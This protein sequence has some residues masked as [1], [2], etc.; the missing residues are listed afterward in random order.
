MASTATSPFSLMLTYAASSPLPT[1]DFIAPS[2]SF[3]TKPLFRAFSLYPLAL[4]ARERRPSGNGPYDVVVAALAAEAEV[5]EAVEEVE[6][7]EGDAVSTA[8]PPKPK[9]GKAALLLKRD[10]TRSKRF[11]EIQKLRENK[12][13]YDLQTAISLLKQMAS[14]RFVETAEAHFRLNIDPKY[15]DQQLRATVNLPKGTGQTVKVAVLTQGMGL[16]VYNIPFLGCQGTI[17]RLKL[18]VR[19][20]SQWRW[21]EIALRGPPYDGSSEH[22]HF[23]KASSITWTA[24]KHPLGEKFDEAKNAGAD[25]VGG[26]D[27]IEQIKGGFMDFDKLIA[28]PDMMPKVASLGKLLGPRGL[29][30]NPKA[31]TVTT[32]IPQAIAEFKKGKVEY[33]ADKTGIVHLPFGKADFSEEDLLANLIAAVKSVETNKPSGAKGVYWRSAPHM[34]FHGAFYSIK[35]K[36][37]A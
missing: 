16:G 24:N 34:L 13:E 4:Q 36:G 29:M 10:R 37:D 8:P 17:S 23:S 33:R 3:K 22:K 18:W 32:N 6:G 19:G 15:N 20:S 11:L 28:S 25:L 31:G 1:Q 30:P 12:K 7:G 26:E 9:K 14:T 35:Y 21:L 2:L 5:A 27:L